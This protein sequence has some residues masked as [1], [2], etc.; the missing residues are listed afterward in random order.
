[1]KRRKARNE[2]KKREEGEGAPQMKRVKRRKV[3]IENERKE[4]IMARKMGIGKKKG[5][6]Q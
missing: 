5:E 4:N 3:T 2:I 1:M 6:P